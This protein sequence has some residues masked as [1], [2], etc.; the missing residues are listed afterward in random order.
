MSLY[1]FLL[2]KCAATDSD[3]AEPESISSLKEEQMWSAGNRKV[4]VYVF[5][6]FYK[7]S[8]YF[9]N[10]LTNSRLK[11]RVYLIGHGGQVGCRLPVQTTL[12]TKIHN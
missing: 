8:I 3:K 7:R 11:A 5:K 6:T 2:R 1:F 10:C 12:K 9:L 4:K